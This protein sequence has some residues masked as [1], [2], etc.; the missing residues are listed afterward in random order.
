[1]VITHTNVELYK[2]S[3]LE[4]KEIKLQIEVLEIRLERLERRHTI[5]GRSISRENR[6]TIGVSEEGA[7][8]KEEGIEIGISTELKDRD[9]DII[10]T[11]DRVELLTPSKKNKIFKVGAAALVQGVQ[12]RKDNKSYIRVRSTADFEQETTRDPE[13]IRITEGFKKY[14]KEV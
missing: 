4:I 8:R 12:K 11:G 13:N 10:R 2:E 14:N 5:I 9:G 6:G 7:P 3:E 1:M